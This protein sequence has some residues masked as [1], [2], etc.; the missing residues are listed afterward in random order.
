MLLLFSDDVVVQLLL[1]NGVVVDVV[2]LL[3][4]TFLFNIGI[5]GLLDKSIV[6]K[7]IKNKD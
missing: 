1:I 4:P 5:S 6:E 2:D 7:H 3:R